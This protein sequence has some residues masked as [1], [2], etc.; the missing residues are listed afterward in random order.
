MV[1]GNGI[2]WSIDSAIIPNKLV[3]APCQMSHDSDNA[4]RFTTGHTKA[5][6]GILPFLTTSSS[7]PTAGTISPSKSMTN[8]DSSPKALEK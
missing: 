6:L 8:A 1:S 5:T 3:S 4:S 7:T 2:G